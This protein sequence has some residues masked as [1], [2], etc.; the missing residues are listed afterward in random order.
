MQ[1]RC[2]RGL[3]VYHL[4]DLSGRGRRGGEAL[5]S[6]LDCKTPTCY[7]TIVFVRY[8]AEL[9]FVKVLVKMFYQIMNLVGHLIVSFKFGQSLE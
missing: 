2:S 9:L 1:I 8:C 6:I 7:S 5:I 3:V 4:S